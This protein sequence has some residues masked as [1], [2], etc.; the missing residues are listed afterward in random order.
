MNT[1]YKFNTTTWISI[2]ILV[3]HFIVLEMTIFESRLLLHVNIF[4]NR[5]SNLNLPCCRSLI[6]SVKSNFINVSATFLF[7]VTIFMD[8]FLQKW[9]IKYGVSLF[10]VEY[11]QNL[12]IQYVRLKVNKRKEYV[13][14]VMY[15]VSDM[16]LK[17]PPQLLR[18][19]HCIKRS[20]CLLV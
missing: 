3:T 18:Q 5:Y 7:I 8:S 19:N 6:C 9:N 10:C 16:M 17:P 14:H 13:C 12:Y 4:P 2:D 20:F 1:I 15:H 11:F